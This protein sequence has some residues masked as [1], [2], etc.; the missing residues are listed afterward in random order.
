MTKPPGISL[1]SFQLFYRY[2][3]GLLY[4]LNHH[5]CYPVTMLYDLFL[6]RKVD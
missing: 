2:P 1:R 3:H 4:F 6:L 5:L